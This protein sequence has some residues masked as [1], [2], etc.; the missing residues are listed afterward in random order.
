MRV[1]NL[2]RRLVLERPVVVPDGAGGF[3]ETWVV[4]GVVWAEVVAGVGREAAG[5]EINLSQTTYRVTLR[6]APVGSPARP[7]AG[8]R[9]RD[10]VRLLT[11]LAV[12]E[13]D[14][15]GRHLVCSA[16]E[17]VPA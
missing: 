8:N 2:N 1:P 11:V 10:G 3:A 14:P 5:E 6:G 12:A 13:R 16:R 7:V 17:E 15:Q 4:A 9:L